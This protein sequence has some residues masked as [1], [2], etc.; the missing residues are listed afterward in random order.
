[1]R[2]NHG[3]LLV[4]TIAVCYMYNTIQEDLKE[5]LTDCSGRVW[6]RNGNACGASRFYEDSGNASGPSYSF[7]VISIAEKSMR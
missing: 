1:M 7:S 5:P 2:S 4:I 3:T 6:R